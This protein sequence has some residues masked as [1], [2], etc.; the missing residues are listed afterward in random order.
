MLP[1]GGGLAGGW[2]GG[3][4]RY[5]RG[6]QETGG[7][8]CLNTMQF[9]RFSNFSRSSVAMVCHWAVQR[10]QNKDQRHT[11]PFKENRTRTKGIV[12]PST[13][14]AKRI[15]PVSTMAPAPLS[16]KTRR[17]GGGCIQRLGPATPPLVGILFNIE[18]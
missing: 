7:G 2:G 13:K 5:D 14:H 1:W 3:C 16:L 9:P 6:S 8:G 10:V 11:T 17:G 18:K 4:W 15:G 12:P